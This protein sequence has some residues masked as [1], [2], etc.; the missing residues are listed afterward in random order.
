[1]SGLERSA[2]KRKN[3]DSGDTR[4]NDEL[5]IHSHTTNLDMTTAG[6]LPAP[7][8]C[9]FPIHQLPALHAEPI[10]NGLM[11]VN[12]AA[13]G[14]LYSHGCMTGINSRVA[15]AEADS[16]Q[17]IVDNKREAMKISIH[18]ALEVILDF[19]S[20]FKASEH[21]SLEMQKTLLKAHLPGRDLSLFGMGDTWTEW[22]EK[23][24]FKLRE[25][26][27]QP[28]AIQAH[29]PT[30]SE[31]ATRGKLSSTKVRFIGGSDSRY[32]MCTV[33]APF[34]YPEKGAVATISRALQSEEKR[35]FINRI[36]NNPDEEE[37]QYFALINGGRVEMAFCRENRHIKQV[38]GDLAVVDSVMTFIKRQVLL[39]PRVKRMHD[40]K[41]ET[42]E[43]LNSKVNCESQVPHIDCAMDGS[44]QGSMILTP[45]A[46]GT[47][48]WTP[49]EGEKIESLDDLARLWKR[50]I[51]VNHFKTVQDNLPSFSETLQ[52]ALAE[53]DCCRWLIQ[54]FGNLLLPTE[55]L[56]EH[57]KK[58]DSPVGTIFLL[59]GGVVHAGPEHKTERSV[60]FFTVR[61][62][63]AAPYMR[64]DQFRSDTL[65]AAITEIVWSNI[66]Q[67][68]REF[69]LWYLSFYIH[70]C[71]R[72]GKSATAYRK[73]AC[74]LLGFVW[75]V[76]R[77]HKGGGSQFKKN[78]K[79]SE[80]IRERASRS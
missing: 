19:L 47:R 54:S 62:T 76:E 17:S 28:G 72:K 65:M 20:N 56:K 33:P 26:G 45:G 57:Q 12:T 15:R 68:D 78:G 32:Q 22:E 35:K 9:A 48:F 66:T 49:K 38:V 44:Y 42:P 25:V 63:G 50:D 3:R 30:R 14:Y 40:P 77:I 60:L 2:G 8:Y 75:D 61:P 18:S 36:A 6:F 10:N 79:L 4:G 39:D 53:S 67:S 29:F 37:S 41:V 59:P 52:K 71:Y 46:R 43:L 27:F 5:L 7:Y 1:M 74:P 55:C 73:E 16:P 13:H 21:T 31:G 51:L 34:N 58:G 24:L 23:V 70:Q 64:D 69:M 80:V 11:N